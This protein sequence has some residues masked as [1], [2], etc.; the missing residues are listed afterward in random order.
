MYLSDSA[1]HKNHESGHIVVT[2]W[3]D[4]CVGSNSYDVHLARALC[5]Y[6]DTVLDAAKDNRVI[7]YTIPD[8]G[9][10]LEPGHLYLG[11][12]Q[13]HT[14]SYRHV[15]RLSG[16]SSTGRL[17]IAIHVT[18][19]EGDVGFPGHWTL[20]IVV[21]VPVRI[22]A[23]MPIGQLSW[24]TVEG[25]VWCPYGKKSGVKYAQAAGYQDEP[26]PQPSRMFMNRID[27]GDGD[28]CWK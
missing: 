17:G 2:P 19:G 7:R 11:V 18:A 21:A 26:Q 16:K 1:I 10:V 3:R 28:Y 15:P 9:Y 25:E 14:R 22:Y 24:H 20:E 8:E 23:G 13:E 6:A 27:Q 12:T 5:E 4:S